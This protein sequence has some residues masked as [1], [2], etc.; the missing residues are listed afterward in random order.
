MSE[1][2]L[3]GKADKKAKWEKAQ[4]DK[5]AAKA[6]K[7]YRKSGKY[8]DELQAQREQYKR[9]KAALEIQQ[10]MK[11]KFRRARCKLFAFKAFSDMLQI[12]AHRQDRLRWWKQKHTHILISLTPA[13][14][15]GGRQPVYCCW[16]QAD[17]DMGMFLLHGTVC[18]TLF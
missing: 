6:A 18:C 13:A 15:V 8:L 14:V 11:A 16:S 3:S 12:S 4:A 5:R 7:M 1:S 9:E 10:S 2:G 17:E